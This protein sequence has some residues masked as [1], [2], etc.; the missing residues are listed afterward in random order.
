MLYSGVAMPSQRAT[1]WYAQRLK[2]LILWTDTRNRSRYTHDNGWSVAADCTLGRRQR[3]SWLAD[4]IYS[5]WRWQGLWRLPQA[6]MQADA[7]SFVGH[8]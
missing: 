6:R 5:C 1:P 4:W 2:R 7:G 3:E 8:G